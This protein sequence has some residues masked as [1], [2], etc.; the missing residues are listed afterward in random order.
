[1][2]AAVKKKKKNQQAVWTHTFFGFQQYTAVI[3]HPEI[4]CFWLV[5]S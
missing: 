1:M 5:V 3:K 2:S 4:S